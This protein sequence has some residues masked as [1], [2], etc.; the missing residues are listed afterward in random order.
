[1][2]PIATVLF[3]LGLGLS[4]NVQAASCT[5]QADEKKLAGA[6]RNS[7]VQKCERD[8]TANAAAACA[9][10]AD[11]KKL[12]GAARN[13]FVQKCERDHGAAAAPTAPT[14]GAAPTPAAP[15]SAAPAAA[16][17]S[18]Q[19]DKQADEKKLAGAAR[20]SFITKCQKDASGG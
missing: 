18:A 15:A 1:M 3:T 11:E 13:S 17:P 14:A 8:Q 2:N 10:Q 16:P 7:F 19:C 9:K 12:A 20:N 5:A 4:L 6:A